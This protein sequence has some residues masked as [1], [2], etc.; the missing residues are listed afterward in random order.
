MISSLAEI[1]RFRQLLRSLTVRNLK[2]KYQRSVLGFI[3][4]LLNPLFT[5]ALLVLVFGWLVRIPVNSYWAFLLSG[6]F[7]WNFVLQTLLGATWVLAEHSGLRRSVAFPSEVLILA[8]TGS[9]L[10]EY[11]V[12]TGVALVLL[13]AFHHHSVPSA[14]LFLPLLVVLQVL[15]TLGLVLPISALALFYTDLQHAMPVVTTMLFYVSPVFYPAELVPEAARTV[16]FLNPFAG[17]LTL[18]HVVLYEGRVPP[19]SLVAIV[20]SVAVL[21]ASLGYGVFSRYK[22]YLAEIA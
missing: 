12:E 15:V 4:T 10:V 8:A 16:Y 2:V 6:Y 9:R 3:W 13:A 17:L 19:P 18:F 7:V 21:L 11:A 14:W 1:W 22:P 5:V 20:A